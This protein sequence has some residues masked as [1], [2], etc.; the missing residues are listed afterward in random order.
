LLF[1][2]Y[3]LIFL[4]LPVTRMDFLNKSDYKTPLLFPVRFDRSAKVIHVLDETRLPWEETYIDVRT[5]LEAERVLFEM[6]T[7][8]F[9]QVLLF[10]YTVLL[11]TLGQSAGEP[12]TTIDAVA[13]RFKEKR[14]TFDF[15]SLAALLKNAAARQPRA[16]L[17]EVAEGF[18]RGFD[19][20]RRKRALSLAQI[21][22]SPANILTLCNVNGEL[23][24]LYYALKSLG[25]QAHF[26]V[27]E[28]RPYL[29]GTRLTLF[30]LQREGIPATLLCDNQA[31]F[32][33]RE[34]RI[35]AVVA[36]ADRANKKGDVINKIGTYALARLARY[37]GIPFYAYTQYPVDADIKKIPIEQRPPEEVFMFCE[38]FRGTVESIYPNF[39]ITPAEY[40]TAQATPEGL[41]S[42][43]S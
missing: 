24:Y 26:F 28:T 40:I 39:D 6:K 1:D 25:R 11:E 31:A 22:P 30:E 18:I 23:V 36:G 15:L 16:S 43:K 42:R 10:L 34:K 9:G 21:L 12:A 8:A 2:F 4:P 41:I 13:R 37:Y 17:D 5:L 20:L 7:R 29:Q 14:P 3:Y 27:S 33:M 35:T 19:A 38:A 32:L